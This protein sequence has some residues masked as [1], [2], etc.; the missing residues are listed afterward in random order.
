M[1]NKPLTFQGSDT[2]PVE[3]AAPPPPE[4]IEA[5]ALSIESMVNAPG[6]SEFLPDYVKE[7]TEAFIASM[8]R[9]AGEIRN[10]PRVRALRPS[11]TPVVPAAKPVQH[12]AQSAGGDAVKNA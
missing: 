12:D 1:S 5:T 4:I 3:R 10:P 11:L 7:A 2:K 6:S 8:K 9:W